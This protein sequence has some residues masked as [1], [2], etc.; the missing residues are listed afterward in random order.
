MR[1]PFRKAAT[2]MSEDDIDC[3]VIG[4]GPAGLT[5][6]IYLAR[7]RR[8]IAVIDGGN[9]RAALIPVSHNYPGFAKGISGSDLLNTLRSQV[10]EFGVAIHDGHVT[11]LRRSDG[12]YMATIDA[13]EIRARVLLATGIVDEVPG[14]RA[15]T[16][17]YLRAR[18]A[19]ARFATDTTLE[20]AA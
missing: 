8:K 10:K 17:P 11:D 12:G 18:Y 19:I 1:K 6:A 4:G 15:S 14:C 16:A 9:S 13:S 7:Y 2:I 5:A 20:T 3:L